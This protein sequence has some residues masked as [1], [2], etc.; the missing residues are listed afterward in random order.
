MLK[1]LAMMVQTAPEGEP[2]FAL[3]MREH[4]ELCGQFARAFGNSQ[5]QPLDP[6]AECLYAVENHDRGWDA[7]DANP[8]LDPETRLPYSLARTPP[9]DNQKTITASPDFNE[10]H[11]PYCALLVS[12]HTWGLY[13]RRY[14]ISQFVVRE[15]ISTSIPISEVHRKEIEARL[16]GE[17]ERQKRLTSTIAAQNGR[18][19]WVAPPNVM[20]N[21]KQLQFFD[22]LSLYFHL[23]HESERGEEV[24]IHVPKSAEADV[25]ITLRA[26]GGGTYTLDPFPFAQDTLR[27]VCRGRYVRPFPPDAPPADLGAALRSLPSDSQAYV[28]VPGS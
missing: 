15:R 23:R 17:V 27:V 26:A 8:K 28:L 7:Y 5:F 19:G 4:L 20:R 10:R 13:N 1:V 18:A 24:Y 2:H 16:N 3:F 9:E 11:D 22:T 6:Y 21:Y 12:M 25:S 14:G